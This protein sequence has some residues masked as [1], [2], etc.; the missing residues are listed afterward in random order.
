[1]LDNKRYPHW[2][3]TEHERPILSFNNGVW[4]ADWAW[5]IIPV[6][7]FAISYLLHVL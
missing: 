2:I 4:I 7:V 1:M 5:L 6:V 3:D